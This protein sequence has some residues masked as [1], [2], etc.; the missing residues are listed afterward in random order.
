MKK[1]ILTTILA[2]CALQAALAQV[3]VD[4]LTL[5]NG[6][7]LKGKVVA[8]SGSSVFFKT[9]DGTLFKQFNAEDIVSL[10]QESLSRHEYNLLRGFT[11]D[12]KCTRNYVP[13]SRRQ[14]YGAFVE[15]LGG[16]STSSYGWF[17][18]TTSQ[19][20]FISPVLFA[21]AGTGVNMK[22]EYSSYDYRG[23]IRKTSMSVP[24]FA[25]ARYYFINNRNCSPYIDGKIGYALPLYDAIAAD[26][27]GNSNN[28]YSA[29]RTKGLYFNISVGVEINR[30]TLALGLTGSN[31]QGIDFGEDTYMNQS[32]MAKR[33]RNYYYA[34]SFVNAAWHLNVGF[35]F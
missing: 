31:T 5:E 1:I 32:G 14:G 3:R 19:G 28:S 17:D 29:Y 30:I 18:V 9:A 16:Y 26:N 27:A 6:N 4:T 13:S 20:Y 10:G 7:V 15:A 11:R 22:I 2:L 25:T 21:G 12:G 23:T 33:W 34:Y 24:I 8:K 35:R